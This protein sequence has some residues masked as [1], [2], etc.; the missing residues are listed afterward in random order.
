MQLLVRL[1]GW[2]PVSLLVC[3]EV[4]VSVLVCCDHQW[5]KHGYLCMNFSS[6]LF[7]WCQRY[8][9]VIAALFMR[10]LQASW[11]QRQCYAPF[12]T[13]HQ[14]P[15]TDYKSTC[16][17]FTT[18]EV[19]CTILHIAPTTSQRL[20]VQLAVFTCNLRL[21]CGAMCR[22]VP[23][24]AIVVNKLIFYTAAQLHKQFINQW[25][26][27]SLGVKRANQYIFYRFQNNWMTDCTSC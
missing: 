8:W 7:W 25:H 2:S 19:L 14:Q 23:G 22:I 24:T 4:R 26:C 21:V 17:S 10:P 20:Q 5:G 15:V 9:F 6:T 12:C 3:H 16:S 11:L 18:M 13:L 1:T 27:L